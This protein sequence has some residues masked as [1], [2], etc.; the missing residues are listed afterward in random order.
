MACSYSQ[1]PGV[2]STEAYSPVIHDVTWRIFLVIYLTR[3]Y[4]AKIINIKT[5]FLYG[6]LEEEIYM[7]YTEGLEHYEDKCLYLRKTIYGLV[8]AA[9]QYWKKFTEKLKERGFKGGRQTHVYFCVLM[10]M[11]L[12][13]LPY[14]W[15]TA[16]KLEIL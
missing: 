5:T 3:K 4:D 12:C 6:D 14:T 16:Y 1:I 2:D 7:K 8:Q 15:M 11:E 9:R 10:R 13:L